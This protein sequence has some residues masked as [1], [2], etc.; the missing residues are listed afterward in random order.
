[1]KLLVALASTA[2]FLSAA[3][4]EKPR[5]VEKVDEPAK[6]AAESPVQENSTSHVMAQRHGTPHVKDPK[7][8]R[9]FC[10]PKGYE[11]QTPKEFPEGIEGVECGGACSTA[12]P[13][14][15]PDDE[16]HTCKPSHTCNVTCSEVCCICLRECI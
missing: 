12:E 3:V 9:M 4:Q 1:M 14:H 11:G 6:A 10:K 8:C 7:E 13:P 16:D 5:T 15:G 2:F